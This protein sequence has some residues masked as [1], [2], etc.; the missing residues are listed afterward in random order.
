MND[1]PQLS[2]TFA[3]RHIGPRPDEIARMVELLGYDDVD[4]LVDAAVPASIRSAEAL[5]LPE[6]ASEVDALTELR[7]LA[8]RNTVA[9]SMIGQGYYG[10]FTP[11]VIVRRLVENPAWY[12]AYTPYQPEISQGRLEAL[13]NF[14]T[15]VSDLTGLPT[16]NAS[17]LDE[18]TAAA[19]A[20]TLA[21]R[22]NKKSK[23]DRFLVDADT[24]AQT[25]AV[26]QTRA[27]ALGI[28]VVVADT[29]DGLPDGD[30]FGLLVQYPGSNGVVRDLKPLIEAAHGRDT[31]VAVAS[32]LLALTVLEAPGEAGADIVIGSSQRFGVP[33]FYGGPHAGFMSVRSG[34]ERSLPG[35]LVGVSVDTDGA[36]AYRL[37]LQ[38]RE[39]HIR[40]EKATSNICTAQVLLAV[41]ASMY[42]VYHGPDGLRAIAERVHSYAGKLAASLRAGGVEVVH[43]DFFDTVLA[44]VPGRAADVVDAARQNGIWLRLVDADH[45]GISCD[46]KTDVATLTR[47]CQSFGVQYDDTLEAAALSV[48]RTTEYL[49][50]PVFNTHRSETAMLRYLRKLSDKDYA[51]DRGM[52]PLGSC[53][54]KL[55]ATTEM[56]PVTWPEFADL[57]PL[58]PIEDAAGYVKLIG[59]LERWLAEVTGY[60]KVSIQPNAGSQGELAGLL[61]IRGYH[62]ANG[63]E[64][65][66]VCLIPASAHGTNAA[67]AVMAGMKVVVVK[68]NDDGTIDLDD[69]RAKASEHAA[70]LAAIM[71]TYPST[72]GVYEESVREVCRIVHDHGGQVYVDGANLNALLGL[73]KP[74]EFGGDVSHLNLHKTFCIPHGG[75]GPGVGPVAV[76]AHLAPYLPNHPLLD[77]A[78]PDSGVGPISAAPFGSAGV[79]AISWAYIRMMGAEGLTA[80]T[81]AA[82]LTAN[83]VAKRLE[84]AFPVLYTGENGLVAHECILDLRPMTKET[85][86]SVDDV[87]KRLIDYGFHAPTMSFPVA[88]TLMV[89]PT[90]SEDLG[91]LDRFCDAMIAI[92]H[93][94][95][96]VAAGEWPA[97]DNPLVNAPHT[98]ESVINDKWEH[99]YTREEAAF[100]RS[101][102]RA[103]KYWPPVRRIDGAYGD[104]NLICS[105][106]APEAFE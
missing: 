6:P 81:K 94:I 10:T 11:S 48:P 73:A 55:N 15:V 64:D 84:G 57:H 31:L 3:D 1:T 51:L 101:V 12:T 78:G 23:S 22:S 89:E 52:I 98:A 19:E 93:E 86:I 47:V 70:K 30:F 83:Y 91:E 38:T 76:A 32:D 42:A 88:G 68:G 41:V 26:V 103:S 5:R 77:Q 54:M 82:V 7:Q 61:A 44:R 43:G 2:A 104:R 102:D 80:A 85:G 18:G 39:Q 49:T 96:R 17:L 74:G 66:N 92:R 33:L 71:I 65:R 90:E 46:E 95:D 58:A 45:V 36:P 53:T 69:L 100:P 67:S 87:A 28:E 62:R 56:E 29:T 4:A 8:A 99:A 16:A 72:H 50:H 63:S 75:G 9:T 13:L 40:R 20:M 105:C 24:F 21:H 34:L 59:Q 14:Q 37:A 27:E 79:L 35:R 25:I 106:P 97:A 60:A